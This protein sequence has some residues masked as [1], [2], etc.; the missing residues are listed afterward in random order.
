MGVLEMQ[1]IKV[2]MD[3]KLQ[4]TGAIVYIHSFY[5]EGYMILNVWNKNF[6]IFEF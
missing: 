4:T 3:R 6:K 5:F 2:K 1:D